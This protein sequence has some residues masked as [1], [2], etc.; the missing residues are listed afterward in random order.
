[1]KRLIFTILITAG[2]SS[3]ANAYS[4]G[5]GTVG[6]PFQIAIANDLLELA[7][8]TGD[9]GAYFILTADIDLGSSGTFTTAV[10]APD[11]DNSTSGHQGVKFTGVF[12]GAG[13]KISNLTIDTHG[14]P[15]DYLGLFGY[16]DGGQIKNLRLENV[17]FTGGDDSYCIGGLVGWNQGNISNCYSTGTIIGG[18]N[19]TSLGG[20]AGHNNGIISSCYSTGTVAGGKSWL[21]G[22]GGVNTGNINNC[23][24]TGDVTGGDDSYALGGTAGFSNGNISNCYSTG[25]VNGK[26]SLG[27]LVGHNA[28]VSGAISNSYSTGDVNGGAGSGNLGG[29]VGYNEG[30]SMSNCYSTGNVSGEDDS[31]KI[32]G[33]VGEN[34]SGGNISNCSS[35]GAV[36]GGNGSNWLGGL[37]GYNNSGSISNCS[38]TG[39]VAGGVGSTTLGGLVGYN[40]SG[41]IS[42][43]YS[44]GTVIGAFNLGGLV[45]YT[46]GGSISSCY[47][48]DRGGPYGDGTPLSDEAMKHQASFVGWDFVG[49][50]VNGTQDFWA[51]IE[52]VGYPKL[53]ALGAYSGGTGT[54]D[55]PFQIATVA[56]LLT[57]AT[58][59]KNY[60]KYFVLTADIDL[61]SSGPFTT[62]VIAPDTNNS[63]N[64]FDKTAFTGVFDGAGHKISNLTINTAGSGNDYL[65]LFGCVGYNS[66]IKNLVLEN[67]SI[68]GGNDSHHLSGMVGYNNG[69]ISNCF[70]T[71]T[72]TGGDNSSYLGGLVGLNGDGSIRNCYSTGTVTGT[73]FLGGIA[74]SNGNSIS[75]CSSTGN[76]TGGVN[77]YS[78]G[79][80][81]GVN[82]GDISNCYSKG[83]VTGED[84]SNWLGGLVGVNSYGNISN[85]YSTCTVIGGDN[86]SDLGGLVGYNNRG[87][88]SNSYS[89]GKVTGGV[90]LNDLGGLVGFNEDGSISDCYS[91][92][93]VTGGTNY[94]GGLVGINTGSISNCYFLTGSGPDD[95]NGIPLTDEAM[96]HQASFVGWD[97]VGETI[98]GPNDVWWINEGVD[99]PKLSWQI[100]V[101]KCSVTSGSKINSDKIS[102][103]GI[104]YATAD[105]FND[106]NFVEVTIDSEDMVTPCVQKFP[107]NGKTFRK[108]NYSY[109]GTE[110]GVNKSF[111]YNIKSG[112]FSFAA[113]NVDLSGLGCPL[114]F[115][116]RVSDYFGTAEVNETIVNGRKPIPI[117]LMMGVKNSLRVDKMQ[118]KQSTKQKSDQLIVTGGFAAEDADVNMV[119]YDLNITLAGD[120]FTIPQGKLKPNKYNNRF[121]CSKVLL[122]NGIASV[123]FNFKTCRFKV[124]IKKTEIDDI[125][126]LVDF[127]IMI[128][129]DYEE[130]VDVVLP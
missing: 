45:G 32:G 85:S 62:A 67:I 88:V 106:G 112:K 22:I 99:Y 29:L 66:E 6:D 42:N 92:G 50:A 120:P 110:N 41:D 87:N 69:S 115:E 95:G 98:N 20:L 16:T 11:T 1:M 51:I 130:N 59:T 46:D 49:E 7:A 18:D 128:G 35:I 17:R 90:G 108:G 68:T 94:L 74:G 39:A 80:L 48:L 121:T 109:S 3:I 97:F 30:G 100:K 64:S 56:D 57:L 119:E 4:G 54:A 129:V 43:C 71:G 86:S 23:Y 76:V 124:T 111:K 52:G 10:I 14:A 104:M 31:I 70:S 26:S 53:S 96:K 12:D 117:N 72:V 37:V 116:I 63:N 107:I 24:S 122:P 47:F 123:D 77:S 8:T 78:L 91:T 118:V 81:L 75:N 103:S 89:T 13:H 125:H 101:V 19:S 127:G 79:G 38:S 36:T 60:D 21:G 15:N 25:A 83:T 126:G 82:Y 105:D 40:N 55:D 34:G 93:A 65:G 44:T 33:L 84:N 73:S 5:S 102:F 28:S 61:G 58:N 27:G 9:Y 2:L 113:K 114:T